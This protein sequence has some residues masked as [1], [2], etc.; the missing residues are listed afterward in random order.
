MWYVTQNPAVATL[1]Q[2]RVCRNHGVA[3]VHAR[4]SEKSG[5]SPNEIAC[6]GGITLRTDWTGFPET[7]VGCMRRG[8]GQFGRSRRQQEPCTRPKWQCNKRTIAHFLNRLEPMRIGWITGLC[9]NRVLRGATRANA[10]GVHNDTVGATITLLTLRNQL[11]RLACTSSTK[12][13]DNASVSWPE[14]LHAFVQRTVT[15]LRV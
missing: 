4:T 14:R 5:T 15:I 10:R 6:L 8:P 1:A 3:Y 13:Y 12:T 2:A 9:G 11:H 7:V